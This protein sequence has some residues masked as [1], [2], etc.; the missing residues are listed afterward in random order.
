MKGR[1]CAERG[2]VWLLR[3]VGVNDMGWGKL[4][5]CFDANLA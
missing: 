5:S 1:Q 2:G 4:K 3:L